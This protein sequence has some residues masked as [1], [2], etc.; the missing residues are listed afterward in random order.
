MPHLRFPALSPLFRGR[1]PRK[2]LYESP[3]PKSTASGLRQTRQAVDLRLTNLLIYCYFTKRLRT[4]SL[5]SFPKRSGGPGHKTRHPN[6][7]T[8][9][10]HRRDRMAVEP[11][12]Q[13]V[14][15]P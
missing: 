2:G 13:G 6:A 3:C 1:H 5:R 15:R 10:G 8:A 4:L 9:G 14:F 11:V 7:F 12:S